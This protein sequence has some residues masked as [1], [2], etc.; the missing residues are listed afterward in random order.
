MTLLRL[1]P[2]AHLLLELLAGILLAAIF[3]AS[4]HIAAHVYYAL[5]GTP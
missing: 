4:I 2:R 1:T 5:G 3:L